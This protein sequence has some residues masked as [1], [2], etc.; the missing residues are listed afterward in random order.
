MQ[1][2]TIATTVQEN[3]ARVRAEIAAACA[4]AGRNPDDVTLIGVTKTVDRAVV[5]ALVAAGVR[6]IGENRVQDAVA[7][8]GWRSPSPPLPDDVRLHMIGN[9][10][11]NKARDIVRLF[12]C[13]HSLNRPELADALHHEATKQR[14]R[15]SVLIEV[16]MAGEESKQ[17]I[18]PDGVSDLLGYV[19][20]NTPTLD[21]IGLMTIGPLVTEAESTRPAFQALSALR[22]RLRDTYPT[23]PLPVLS[24]GMSNDYP[25]AVEEGATHVRVGRALFAGLPSPG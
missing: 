4:R 10:Q 9:A 1:T 21:P 12:T 13:V 7:K 14:K 15:L 3:V 24:M 19:I 18:D 16:N 23:L 20:A 11:T 6:D 8:L 2:A 17:G 25:V 22:E 5:D